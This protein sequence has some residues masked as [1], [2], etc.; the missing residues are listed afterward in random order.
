[1]AE[2]L[3]GPL[4]GE[5]AALRDSCLWLAIKIAR[6]Y[7][8]AWMS[9]RGGRAGGGQGMASIYEFD[10]AAF[11]GLDKAARYFDPA[12][13]FR[14]TTYCHPVVVQAC[15]QHMAF[16]KGQRRSVGQGNPQREVF[17]RSTW[18]VPG[19]VVGYG[20]ADAAQAIAGGDRSAHSDRM[21]EAMDAKQIVA[22]MMA[23][24][25]ERER[26]AVLLAGLDCKLDA[27]GA[28]LGCTKERARQI[29]KEVRQS[30]GVLAA[31]GMRW[32][33]K[34]RRARGYSK[35]KAKAKG[36]RKAKTWE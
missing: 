19:A 17:V 33:G 32:D 15:K 29:I 11:L 23:V 7:A 10:G 8:K 1:M 2:A 35:M 21:G 20:D 5:L 4:T 24:L 30:A 14:F 16:L 28:V 25:S 13:G 9:E 3:T 12:R 6:R 27:I 31:T 22:R 26:E 18:K 36:R 34:Q